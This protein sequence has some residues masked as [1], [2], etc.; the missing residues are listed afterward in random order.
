MPTR[1][2][3]MLANAPSSQ[4]ILSQLKYPASW[5]SYFTA[6]PSEEVLECLQVCARASA[7]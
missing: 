5:T 2:G 4:T 3:V 6:M 1:A 7:I